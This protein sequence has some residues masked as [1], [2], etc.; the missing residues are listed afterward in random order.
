MASTG[1]RSLVRGI[2]GCAG[3][4]DKC[5]LASTGPRSRERGIPMAPRNGIERNMLQRGRAHVSAESALLLVPPGQAGNTFVATA[6]LSRNIV[7]PFAFIDGCLFLSLL[8]LH[9]AS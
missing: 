8:K 1:P 3:V 7:P 4:W 5:C 6:C 2:R 9:C